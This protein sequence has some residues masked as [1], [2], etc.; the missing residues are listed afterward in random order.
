MGE[1]DK[2]IGDRDKY[3]KDRGYIYGEQIN[4]GGHGYIYE[5]QGIHL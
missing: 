4:L 2:S 1:R 3:L 5:G